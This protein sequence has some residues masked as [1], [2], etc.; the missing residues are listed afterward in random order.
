MAVPGRRQTRLQDQIR[1]EMTEMIELELKDPRIGFAA[2]SQVDLRPD[3][4]SAHI[5][6]SVEGEKEA[7]ERTLEGLRSAAGYL[8]HELGM[9][10][11]LR[12]V[13][14]LIFALDHTAEDM[15]RI[16]SL[17]AQANKNP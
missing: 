5:W 9:R 12:R 17:L 16:E 2:V 8:R 7:Q 4:R 15:R 6:V 11:R 1:E 10:L 3:L 14:E 13:P